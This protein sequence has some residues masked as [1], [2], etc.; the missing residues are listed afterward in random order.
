[1]NSRFLELVKVGLN[2][3][4]RS[5]RSKQDSVISIFLNSVKYKGSPRRQ[6]TISRFHHRHLVMRW[7]SGDRN[8]FRPG[9]EWR[10]R[11]DGRLVR[12]SS[13][14]AATF[15]AVQHFVPG[16]ILLIKDSRLAVRYFRAVQRWLE[17]KIQSRWHFTQQ[18]G[19]KVD[20]NISSNVKKQ[21]D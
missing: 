9:N 5:C 21:V 3:E 8:S 17:E 7:K 18:Q 2:S 6:G 4:I 13:L 19:R 20:T 11:Q 15:A 12:G 14:V 1:M 16:I 10:A